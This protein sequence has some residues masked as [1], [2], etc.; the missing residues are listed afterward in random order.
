MQRITVDG[1]DRTYQLFIPAAPAEAPALVIVL[2]GGKGSGTQIMR[3]TRHRFNTLADE[4]GAII[5]Y[6]DAIDGLWDFGEGAVSEALPF[7][8]DDLKFLRQM[9]TRISA[10]HNVDPDRI[11]ATGISR[12]GQASFALACKSPGLIRAIAPVAMPL[13]D[14]LEDDCTGTVPLPMLL[15]HGTDDPIVPYEG[16]PIT[17]GKTDRG[18]VLSAEDTLS[19]FAARNQCGPER[20]ISAQ[21]E[22]TRIQ[23][24]GCKAPLRH[25]RVDGGGH[26]WPSARRGL[27]AFV[28][29]PTN[30]DINATDEIWAFFNQFR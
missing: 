13:P 3:Y 25:Y 26:T 23:V 24:Q 10:E 5:A 18:D 27:A 28:V 9:I 15:I 29:G 21:G 16:G 20:S 2:H 11:F 19:L 30:T 12:G 6:P 8:R 17:V 4:T 1:L 14:Y 22:V 7:R